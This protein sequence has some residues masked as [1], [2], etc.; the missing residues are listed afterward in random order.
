MLRSPVSAPGRRRGAVAVLVATCMTALIAVVAIAVDGA[1]LMSSKRFAQATADT[2]ALASASTILA[3]VTDGHDSNGKA[4]QAAEEAARF[5]SS[6]R[7]DVTLVNVTVKISPQPPVVPSV[8][9]MDANG[10]LLE[11]YVEVIVEYKQKRYFSTLWG[12]EDLTIQARAVARGGFARDRDGVLV[13]D[14]DDPMALHVAGGGA[15]LRLNVVSSDIIVNSTVAGTPGAAVAEGGATV[16]APGMSVGGVEMTNG[17]GLFDLQTPVEQYAPPTPDPLRN[18]PP[19][20]PVLLGLTTIQGG[21]VYVSTPNPNGTKVTLDPGIYPRGITLMGNT[22]EFLYVTMNPGIYYLVD[23]GF[24][25]SGNVSVVGDGVMIYNGSPP[26]TVPGISNGISVTGAATLK[27]TPLNSTDPYASIY[28]GM[29]FYV[30]RDSGTPILLTGNS[31]T[32]IRG[33]VYAPSSPVSVLGTGDAVIGSR[34]ISR[35]LDVGGSG[36]LTIAYDPQLPPRDR[37]LQLVE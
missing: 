17:N 1:M 9:I 33:V 26:S 35:T 31:G 25:V 28:N 30:N 14:R 12:S 19:P 32:D 8:T 21:G 37:I 29:T 18:L 34:Y 24:T 15:A 10:Q 27:L 2:A 4:R 5:N 36:T 3:R 22:G 7:T 6:G 11:G 23:G 20:D 13:L 16:S